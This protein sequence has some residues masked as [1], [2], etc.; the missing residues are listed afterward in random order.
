MS[1]KIL[2]ER[3]FKEPVSPDILK[4]IEDIRIKALR[5]RGY[6]GGETMIDAEDDRNVLVISLWSSVTDWT[7]WYGGKDWKSLEK[8]LIP[9]LA[10]PVKVRVFIAGADYAKSKG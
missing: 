9:Y 4:V 2:I 3:R 8:Q 7:T 1:T 6:I 5:Q 10:E